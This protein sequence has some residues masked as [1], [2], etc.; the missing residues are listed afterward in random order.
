[1]GRG[2]TTGLPQFVTPV[3]IFRLGDSTC[4]HPA[5]SRRG[6]AIRRSEIPGPLDSSGARR[7]FVQP[8]VVNF[9][10]AL[11][12]MAQTLIPT[13]TIQ[14]PLWQQGG[15]SKSPDSGTSLAGSPGDP[16]PGEENGQKA[17]VHNEKDDDVHWL[18]VGERRSD[19]DQAPEDAGQDQPRGNRRSFPPPP[20]VALSQPDL[21]PSIAASSF[22]FGTSGPRCRETSQPQWTSSQT[23]L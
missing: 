12:T 22:R 20:R 17:R 16:S 14:A 21:Y 3:S 19:R 4:L 9:L 23:F 8:A 13:A 11:V 5:R 15:G 2:P 6:L 1:M 7:R 18:D 10:F